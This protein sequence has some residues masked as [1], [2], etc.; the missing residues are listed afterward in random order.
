[1]PETDITDHSPVLPGELPPEMFLRI[2]GLYDEGACLK[3]YELGNAKRPLQQWRG[4]DAA[5]LAGRIALNLGASRL[6][7]RQHVRAFH[8]A[9]ERLKTQAYYLET[10]L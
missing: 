8:D 3:A 10:F 9:P 1:M 7:F 5:I 2:Q 4:A 6:A